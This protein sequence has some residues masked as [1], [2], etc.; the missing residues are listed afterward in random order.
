MHTLKKNQGDDEAEADL[1][2]AYDG[3]EWNFLDKVLKPF[4]GK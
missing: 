3:V 4:T 2:K 1:R